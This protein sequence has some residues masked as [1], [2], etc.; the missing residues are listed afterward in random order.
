MQLDRTGIYEFHLVNGDVGKD[1]GVD[2]RMGDVDG[3]IVEGLIVE[4][5]G[6]ERDG[7]EFG[8][9]GDAQGIQ[10]AA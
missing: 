6:V 8:G 10:L 1:E 5:I 9:G 2:L 4:L 3:N 7:V